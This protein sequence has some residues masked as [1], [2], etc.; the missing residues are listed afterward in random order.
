MAIENNPEATVADELG[1]RAVV[2]GDS[3]YAYIT[4]GVLSRFLFKDEV[5]EILV[6]SQIHCY[7]ALQRV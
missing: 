4:K 3:G 5:R 7:L 6:N 2:T 1:Q